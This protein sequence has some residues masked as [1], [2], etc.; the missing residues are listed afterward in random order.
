MTAEPTADSVAARVSS[1]ED[2]IIR[3]ICFSGSCSEEEA[4]ENLARIK[5]LIPDEKSLILMDMTAVR[6]ILPENKKFY[7]AVISSG[8][9]YAA[10]VLLGQSVSSAL[11]DFYRS[12]GSLPGA[13]KKLFNDET[14]ALEWLKNSKVSTSAPA[15]SDMGQE[16]VGVLIYEPALQQQN[17]LIHT[18]I[19]NGIKCLCVKDKRDI[20]PRVALATMYLDRGETDRARQVLSQALSALQPEAAGPDIPAKPA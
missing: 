20:F 17:P 11:A 8:Y 18:C 4:Q 13:P 19:K 3:V 10:A 1:S 7:E 2:G 6:N 5:N 16:Q 15:S 9:V 12:I 14:K